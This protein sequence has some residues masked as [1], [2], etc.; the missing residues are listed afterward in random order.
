MKWVVDQLN[1]DSRLKK[2]MYCK[3]NL[4]T[5]QNTVQKARNSTYHVE[6]VSRNLQTW[7]DIMPSRRKLGMILENKMFDNWSYQKMSTEFPVKV[8]GWKSIL[9]IFR[10]FFVHQSLILAHL[11]DL[12]LFTKY[13]NFIGVCSILAKKLTNFDTLK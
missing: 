7:I 12:T 1:L 5:N 8:C 13:G 3:S 6:S 4:S 9:E 11:L 10:C 2:K